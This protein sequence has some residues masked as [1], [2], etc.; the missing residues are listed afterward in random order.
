MKMEWA[1]EQL[2]QAN[3]NHQRQIIPILME[4]TMWVSTEVQNTG[5]LIQMHK[6]FHK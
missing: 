1:Q 2:M 3:K 6:D 4:I 5:Q